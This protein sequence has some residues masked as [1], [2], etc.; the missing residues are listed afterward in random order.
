MSGTQTVLAV[1]LFGLNAR[2]YLSMFV[3]GIA[4]NTSLPRSLPL[5]SNQHAES[6]DMS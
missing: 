3:I 2:G 4:S 1:Y 5:C 6:R